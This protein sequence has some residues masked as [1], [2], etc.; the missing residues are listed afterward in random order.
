MPFWLLLLKK[1]I[2]IKK[3]VIKMMIKMIKIKNKRGRRWRR[4]GC[5][6]NR[7][8]GNKQSL[9]NTLMEDRKKEGMNEGIDRDKTSPLSPMTSTPLLYMA[10]LCITFHPGN[11][12]MEIDH[13]AVLSLS[14]SPTLLPL[15]PL[16][17]SSPTPLSLPPLFPLSSSPLPPLLLLPLSS[18][19]PSP[20]RGKN[21]K[22]EE[23]EEEFFEFV[24]A[25][26]YEELF[27]YYERA[28]SSQCHPRK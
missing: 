19:A 14:H 16:L 27:V 28:N 25:F 12:M 20:V 13:H 15:L 7:R 4:G 23:E 26:V 17:S 9:M 10:N 22:N 11:T 18:F 5:D 3:M 2:I 21:G 6:R 1:I 24:F 8:N